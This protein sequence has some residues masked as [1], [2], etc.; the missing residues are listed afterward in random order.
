MDEILDGR[1]ATKL[2]LVID[3]LDSSTGTM[4]IIDDDDDQEMNKVGKGKNEDALEQF[5]G[6]LL[7][8]LMYQVVVKAQVAW[9]HRKTRSL[10]SIQGRIG[11]NL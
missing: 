2:P 3:I 10:G 5:R 4:G 8:A 9:H 6:C 1:P 7:L 11:C